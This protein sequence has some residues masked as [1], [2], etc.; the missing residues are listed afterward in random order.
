[1][2]V[3]GYH[4]WTDVIAGASVGVA[5]DVLVVAAHGEGPEEL[6]AGSRHR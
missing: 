4:D 2:S 1:M 6:G 5:I 3:A